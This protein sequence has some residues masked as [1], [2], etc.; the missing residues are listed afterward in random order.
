MSYDSKLYYLSWCVEWKFLFLRVITRSIYQP[1]KDSNLLNVTRYTLAIRKTRKICLG[2]V[3]TV[4]KLIRD[5]ISCSWHIDNFLHS[6]MA[7]IWILRIH[8]KKLSL[9][10]LKNCRR[11][12]ATVA[13]TS[14]ILPPLWHL[15]RLFARSGLSYFLPIKIKLIT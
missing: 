1:L 5:R 3:L 6:C 7:V 11:I 4:L 9:I 15:W 12:S 2:L 14:C 10:G 13:L 8:F